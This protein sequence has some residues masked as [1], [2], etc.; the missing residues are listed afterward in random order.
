MEGYITSA[1]VLP[2]PLVLVLVLVT[3]M[4]RATLGTTTTV[5]SRALLASG[6]AG[7]TQSSWNPW[8][9]GEG[10][11]QVH[12]VVGSSPPELGEVVSARLQLL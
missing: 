4:R 7:R 12:L 2:L 6:S 9:D 3:D 11:K 10:P 8:V 1:R 5:T